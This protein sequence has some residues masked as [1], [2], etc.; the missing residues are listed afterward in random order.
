[1]TTVAA[2]GPTRIN[3]APPAKA[4]NSAMRQGND[5]KRFPHAIARSLARMSNATSG[6]LR[7]AR[8]SHALM[9]ATWLYYVPRAAIEE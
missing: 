5:V 2:D 6:L 4:D 7:R 8:I 9:R 1:M 3:D